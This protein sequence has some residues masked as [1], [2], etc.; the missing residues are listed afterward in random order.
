[1]PGQKEYLDKDLLSDRA[2]ELIKKNI[3]NPTPFVFWNAPY[4]RGYKYKVLNNAWK[5]TGALSNCM[6]QP[7]IRWLPS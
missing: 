4:S 5:K 1:M 7:A 6:K 2:W 3:A